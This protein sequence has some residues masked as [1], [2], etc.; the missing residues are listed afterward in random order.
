MKSRHFSTSGATSNNDKQERITLESA[1]LGQQAD[2]HSLRNC[3]VTGGEFSIRTSSHHLKSN[4]V[5][6]AATNTIIHSLGASG[7][8]YE[9]AKKLLLNGTSSV[10]ITSRN[11]QK[12]QRAIDKIKTEI[13]SSDAHIR[14]IECDFTNPISF[15][16]LKPPTTTNDSNQKA[17]FDTLINCAGMTQSS[18]LLTTSPSATSQILKTNLEAPIELSRG[19]LKDYFTLGKRLSKTSSS[20]TTDT[21]TGSP[22]P[23]SFNIITVSSL[24]A[25]RGVPGTSI[26]ATSKAGLIAFTRTLTLEAAAIRSKYPALPPFRANV[27]V[28]G[29][30]D[31][32]MIADFSDAY[33]NKLEGEIPL[34]RYGT[35]VEV[36][37][38]VMFL[39]GNEYAS[40]CVL[41][42]DGGLSA[43]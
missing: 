39:V 8:G 31:T 26:Y 23:P 17:T 43:V 30:I 4:R 15:D 29:Y 10:T 21:S 9:V 38:A 28:P 37:D 6:Q 22:I 5:P 40:N 42:L 27:V 41:N 7:I 19:L 20:S 36:A 24:L 35:A 34:G 11:A 33:R 18:S 14:F 1:P 13:N 12:A 2:K 25:Q 32:P 3:L 16:S